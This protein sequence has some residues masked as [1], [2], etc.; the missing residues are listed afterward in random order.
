MPSNHGHS[1]DE[2]LLKA[3][4]V[5][6]KE[7]LQE[8]YNP[9]ILVAPSSSSARQKSVHHPQSS[10]PQ[11]QQTSPV[12]IPPPP[13]LVHTSTDPEQGNVIPTNG[14]HSYSPLTEKPFGVQGGRQQP[15][16]RTRKGLIII[17]AVVGALIIIAVVIGGAVGGTRHNKGQNQLQQPAGSDGGNNAPVGNTGSKDGQSTSTTTELGGAFSQLTSKTNGATPVPATGL[18]LGL[19]GLGTPTAGGGGGPVPTGRAAPGAP[20]DPTGGTNGMTDNHGMILGG[21]KVVTG[22]SSMEELVDFVR[23][24]HA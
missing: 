12:S 15:F 7:Q 18:P 19:P 3:V 21:E 5:A 23:L 11:P 22:K 1:Y 4:P 17:G 24:L 6:T 13:P 9:D 10:T 16:W 14:S 20:G 8:G 2:S